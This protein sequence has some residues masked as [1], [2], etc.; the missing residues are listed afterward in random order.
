MLPI[1]FALAIISILLFVIVAGRPDEFT[2]LRS[3]T[4]TAPPEKVFPHVNELR[5]W[6]AWSP[7]AKIDPNCKIT[8]AGPPAG[9]DASH[10]W[11]GNNKVGEGKMTIIASAPSNSIRLRLEFLKPFKATNTAEFK[12]TPE[13]GQTLVIWSMTGKNNFFFKIFGLFMDCDTMVGK[14][15]EKGLACLKAVAEAAAKN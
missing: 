15:F 14:D 3:A 12:F 2:V 6:D 10:A 13:D 7:W 5:K 1:L 11:A 4:I 9:V 8:Y